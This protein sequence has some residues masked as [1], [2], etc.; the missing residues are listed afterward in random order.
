MKSEV[1]RWWWWVGLV[2]FWLHGKSLGQVP[3]SEPLVVRS[4]RRSEWRLTSGADEDAAHG[5][6][7]PQIQCENLHGVILS[8]VWWVE[9]CD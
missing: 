2:N 9:E 1:R 3:S 4:R 5:V 7:L 6:E 8:R